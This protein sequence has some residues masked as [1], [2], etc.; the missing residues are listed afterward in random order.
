M[1]KICGQK[2]NVIPPIFRVKTGRPRMVRIREP[3]ENRTQTKYRRTG[4][5]VTCSN[6]G[7]YGHNRKLY[8][9]PILLKAHNDLKLLL[10][11][12][13]VMLLLMNFVLL[14][15]QMDLKLMLLLDPGWLEGEV[16]EEQQ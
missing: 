10:E 16:D 15:K 7:Q 13:E 6:C 14:L 1:E 2:Y 5:S 8:P 9:N 4:T 11:L 12:E 3:D